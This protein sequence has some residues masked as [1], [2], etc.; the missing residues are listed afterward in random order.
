ML[1]LNEVVSWC[2]SV[3]IYAFYSE[4]SG[5]ILRGSLFSDEY[6][7]F[8]PCVELG[9]KPQHTR[10][11]LAVEPLWY[12]S[13]DEARHRLPLRDAFGDPKD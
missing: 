6:C 7:D 5:V 11:D 1:E 10:R 13:V 8:Q 2:C 12:H 4:R 3:G 9:D